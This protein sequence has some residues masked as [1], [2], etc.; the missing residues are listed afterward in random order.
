MV[1]ARMNIICTCAFLPQPNGD[2][3][4]TV[5]RH[6]PPAGGLFSALTEYLLLLWRMQVAMD[7]IAD[8]ASSL[9]ASM[10]GAVVAGLVVMASIYLAL[11][12]VTIPKLDVALEPGTCTLVLCCCCHW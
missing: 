11:G 12:R 1:C 6:D 2:P 10:L 3:K 9:D 5:F 7:Q 4:I 8:V